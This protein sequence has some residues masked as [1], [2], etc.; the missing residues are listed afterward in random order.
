MFG[1]RRSSRKDSGSRGETAPR[2]DDPARGAAPGDPSADKETLA[3]D[4]ALQ[5]AA[6]ALAEAAIPLKMPPMK[7]FRRE[8]PVALTGPRGRIPAPGLAERSGA[9]T[10]QPTRPMAAQTDSDRAGLVRPNLDR[11]A[12]QRP[13]VTASPPAQPRPAQARPAQPRPA[14][15]GPARTPAERLRDEL[16]QAQ[17]GRNLIVGR[18][19]RLTG[20]IRDCDRLVVEGVVD[21][22]IGE[23]RT[24]EIAEGGRVKGRVTVENCEVAG[25]FSGELSVRQLLSLRAGGRARGHLRYGEIEIERGAELCGDV[26]RDDPHGPAAGRPTATPAKDR[27]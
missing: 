27:A 12:L 6:E 4:R 15:A 9:P 22:D 16:S 7:P 21:G 18:D 3:S 26:D 24:L 5:R 19:I 10:G 13:G 8:P 23:T 11:P 17:P 14:Q 25:E 2:R 1:K 20:E